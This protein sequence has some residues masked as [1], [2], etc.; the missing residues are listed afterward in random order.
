MV[1]SKDEGKATAELSGEVRL[2]LQGKGRTL[3]VCVDMRGLS[4]VL[5]QLGLL[6]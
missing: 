6:L 2:I 3:T 5:P 4:H 1:A